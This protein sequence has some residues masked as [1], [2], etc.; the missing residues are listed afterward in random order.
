[1]QS[2]AKKYE[3]YKQKY[4]KLIGGNLDVFM[5]ELISKNQIISHDIYLNNLSSF[6]QYTVPINETYNK[7]VTVI[8]EQHGNLQVNTQ[9]LAVSEYILNLILHKNYKA[10]LEINPE[11]SILD[12]NLAKRLISGNISDIIRRIKNNNSRSKIASSVF[13]S[14]KATSS[15]RSAVSEV[16][17]NEHDKQTTIINNINHFDIREV[18]R[19]MAPLYNLNIDIKISD[20]YN[21][22]ILALPNINNSSKLIGGIN[23]NNYSS[24]NLTFIARVV[25]DIKNNIDF[26]YAQFVPIMKMILADEITKNIT[27]N[28]L[29]DLQFKPQ[30]AKLFENNNKH[31]IDF[32]ITVLREVYKKITDLMILKLVL[33]KNNFQPIV[34]LVGEAHAFNF[35][36]IYKEQLIFSSKDGNIKGSYLF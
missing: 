28:E 10:L 34:I 32:Y 17:P 4:L 22:Y 8:G 36:A 33:D 23:S 13:G 30:Y 19:T 27:V 2:Y 35:N 25:A 7:L 14:C 12:E 18:F 21:Y 29:R 24:N 20:I 26:I 11:L 6:K 15:H 5:Q 9:K 16:K 31:E 1:M 3:K